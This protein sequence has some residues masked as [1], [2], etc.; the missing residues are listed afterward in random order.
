MTTDL[1]TPL[2]VFAGP[3]LRPTDLPVLHAQAVAAGRDLDL[4]PPV[5]RL[6]LLDLVKSTVDS[7]VIMLDGEFGQSLAVSITEIRAVLAAGQPLHGASSMGALRAVECRTL[8][9]TGS[10]WVF[11]QYLSG[12]IESDGDVAL[13]YDPD[14]YVPVTIPLMN[15]RWLL[16]SKA[17]EGLLTS[18]AANA[19]LR[20]AEAAHFHERR[21]AALLRRWR[22]ELP[23]H[24]VEVLEP[25]LAD[26]FALDTWD[27][28][29]LD[30]LDAVRMALGVSEGLAPCATMC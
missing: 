5:R 13:L 18:A 23:A 7:E 24:V 17:S 11:E 28:K 8:G 12:A 20:V 29:R 16:A 25:E 21:P 22:R 3:S 26:S 2:V 6:D 15:V 14:D 10:G 1:A 9:M 30:A 4:R 27:R 19:A